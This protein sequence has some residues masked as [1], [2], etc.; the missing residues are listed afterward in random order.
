MTKKRYMKPEIVSDQLI[1]APAGLCTMMDSTGPAGTDKV[2]F[3]P[4]SGMCSTPTT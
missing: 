3:D 2:S 4:G 1:E